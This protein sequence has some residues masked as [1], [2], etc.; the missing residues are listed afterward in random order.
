MV[1]AVRLVRLDNVA[2]GSAFERGR[3]TFF[4]GWPGWPEY[5]RGKPG[6]QKH[7]ASNAD[8]GFMFRYFVALQ[9]TKFS[10]SL[11]YQSY[12]YAYVLPARLTGVRV[13]H[14]SYWYSAS[15]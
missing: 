12:I 11:S 5:L 2:C 6:K 15:S 4:F 10:I 13:Y 9:F 7:A 3:G 8:G 14:I 1:S